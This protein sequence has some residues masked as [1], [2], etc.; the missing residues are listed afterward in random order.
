MQD[1]TR[2][3]NWDFPG[4]A[5]ACLAVGRFPFSP[6]EAAHVLNQKEKKFFGFGLVFFV[7]VLIFHFLF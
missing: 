6:Q 5:D 4:G 3:H 2:E 1:L 7:V